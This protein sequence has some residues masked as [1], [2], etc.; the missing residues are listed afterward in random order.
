MHILSIL[1]RPQIHEQAE[2]KIPQ[3]G[4]AEGVV[5]EQA[6]AVLEPA[7]KAVEENADPLAD[8]VKSISLN[9]DFRHTAS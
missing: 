5:K 9:S 1:L 2:E 4:E 6:D 8:K 3:P 7:V